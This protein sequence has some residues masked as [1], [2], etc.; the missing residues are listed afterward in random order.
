MATGLKRGQRHSQSELS[1]KVQCK[2]SIQYLRKNLSNRL[3][4]TDEKTPFMAICKLCFTVK[5]YT[6][7]QKCPHLW[8]GVSHIEW[9]P[10]LWNNLLYTRTSSLTVLLKIGFSVDHR[11]WT[12]ALSDNFC[13]SPKADTRSWADGRTDRHDI[14]IIFALSTL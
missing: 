4:A 2:Y 5:R 3:C 11:S 9:N 10:N 6:E 1:N 14:R 12:S 7:N 13:G 8:M